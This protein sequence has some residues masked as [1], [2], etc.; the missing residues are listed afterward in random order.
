MTVIKT[1]SPAKINLTLEVIRRRSDG[2]HELRTVMI[3][4]FNLKDQLEF[5]IKPGVRKITVSCDNPDVP[6]DE[7]NICY[8]AVEIFLDKLGED[9]EISIKINKK[10]PIEAGLGGGSSNAGSTFLVLNEYFKY[11]FSKGQLIEMA[12]EAGKD[13]PFFFS[14]KDGALV[15]GAGEKVGESFDFEAGCF[16]VVNPGVEI[17]TKEAFKKIS[18]KI[19]RMRD[20]DRTNVS[21]RMLEFIKNN[22]EER[23]ASCFYNDFEEMAEKMYPIIKEI[24]QV[25]SVLGAR[26]SLMSGSGSTVFGWFGDQE[27]AKKARKI[28]KNKYKDFL[29]EIG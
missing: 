1:E 8:K 11:P 25:L 10:I 24:K 17:S 9:L 28:I 23:I 3:K 4:L 6:L 13:V 26:G 14:K 21:E 5:N 2:F 12:S 18:A 7:K 15:E 22:S 29:V 16:L 20:G 19:Q 27:E